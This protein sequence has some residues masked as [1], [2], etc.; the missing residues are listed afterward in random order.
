MQ[1]LDAVSRARIELAHRPALR[2]GVV[3]ALALLAGWTALSWSARVES[4]RAGWGESVVV[5]VARADLDPGD[6]IDNAVERQE[7]P[8]AMAPLAATDLVGAFDMGDR[9]SG[10]AR[11]EIAAG[12]ILTPFDVAVHGHPDALLAP[13]QV[14]VAISER[15]RSGARIGDRVMVVSDGFV[16]VPA[17]TVVATHEDRVVV[18]VPE[19]LAAGVSA[20]ALG[21]VGVAVLVRP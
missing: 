17:A 1:V 10:I 18:A 19:D 6:P 8:R 15:I 3:L 13:G 11:R 12:A 16:L 5:L 4:E 9:P 20:A 2:R 7:V 14:A 21:P